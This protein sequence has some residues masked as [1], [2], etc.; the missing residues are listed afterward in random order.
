MVRLQGIF[1]LTHLQLPIHRNHFLLPN[2]FS[3]LQ[4]QTTNLNL[5]QLILQQLRLLFKLSPPFPLQHF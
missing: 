1:Q 2:T 3:Q 5:I 4:L